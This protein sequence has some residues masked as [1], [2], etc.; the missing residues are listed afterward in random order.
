MTLLTFGVK[1]QI[2]TSGLVGWY[3]LDGNTKDTSGNNLNGTGFSITPSTDRFG[4][5]NSCY[6]FN[7]SSSFISVP[8]NNLLDFTTNFTLCGWFKSNS[9]SQIE[10]CILGK[11]RSLNGTGYS[12]LHNGNN[13][14]QTGIGINSTSN[15]E[16]FTSSDNYKQG[17]NFIVGTYN[18]QKLKLYM[19]GVLVDS[20]STTIILSNSQQPLFIGRELL[21]GSL[22][23]Y[24]NGYL[25][26]ILLY[27]RPLSE[28]E[29]SQIYHL[30]DT[31]NIQIVTQPVS[32]NISGGRSTFL[33]TNVSGQNLL[34]QWEFDNGNGFTTI[35]DNCIYN[36]STTNSLSISVVP[37]SLNQQKYRCV[38]S[39][40]FCR[41]TTNIV[42]LSVDTFIVYDTIRVSVTDTLIINTNVTG[43]GGSN[44][45]N[46][47]KIYPNPT[48][49]I[50]FINTGNYQSITGYSVKIINS[51]GQDVYTGLIDKSELSIDMTKWNGKGL[52]FLQLIDGSKNIIDIRKILLQ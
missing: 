4:N 33:N 37:V 21:D 30:G 2:P 9:T 12:L 43:T 34:F 22:S 18:G 11:G 16:L 50:L 7:G 44:T 20:V 28:M 19:N 35:T 49:D 1:G 47:L 51:L 31:C 39:N 15:V 5:L 8:D 36:S 13:G 10:Q 38:I 3:P 41:D 32:K 42:T 45:I 27:N 14:T 40:G 24:F 48:K 26:D 52:Y 29:V 17:W 6:L 23:R 46:T 25:D